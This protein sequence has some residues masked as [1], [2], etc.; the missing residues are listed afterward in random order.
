MNSIESFLL[1]LSPELRYYQIEAQD[2]LK[3][4]RADVSGSSTALKATPK[5]Y[6]E[7]AVGLLQMGVDWFAGTQGVHLGEAKFATG[8]ARKH[9]LYADQL[10]ILQDTA[11]AIYSKVYPI[12]PVNDLRHKFAYRLLPSMNILVGLDPR[13]FDHE[14]DCNNTFGETPE[15]L[16]E[17]GY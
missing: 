3:K 17:D 15:E 1:N 6:S 16:F 10:E 11:S 13:E 8:L 14:P 2:L 4:I 7:M 12:L 5:Q 9:I